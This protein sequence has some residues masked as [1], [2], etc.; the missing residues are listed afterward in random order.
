M[1]CPTRE[2]TVRHTCKANESISHDM[3]RQTLFRPCTL[4][5]TKKVGCSVF[6]RLTFCDDVVP[7]GWLE[8]CIGKSAEYATV[9]K[10]HNQSSKKRH[11]FHLKHTRKYTNSN[12]KIQSN[13]LSD[14]REIG[15]EIL[16]PI[17]DPLPLG[18]AHGTPDKCSF[19]KATAICTL[20]GTRENMGAQ[21]LLIFPSRPGR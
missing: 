14:A 4:S 5:T 3:Y 16:T 17:E 21:L 13:I 10:S 15:C 8:F 2:R 20:R 9:G 12:D 19:W 11:P 18:V 6:W 1:S 7:H